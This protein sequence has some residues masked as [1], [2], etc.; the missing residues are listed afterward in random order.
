VY[1]SS[2]IAPIELRLLFCLVK[3]DSKTPLLEVGAELLSALSWA[4]GGRGR[5]FRR[6]VSS[7]EVSDSAGC[8]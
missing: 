6:A 2:G 8:C 3:F 1:A 7:R 5:L 4:A